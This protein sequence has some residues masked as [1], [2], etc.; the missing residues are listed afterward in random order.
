M[1]LSASIRPFDQRLGSSRRSL[2]RTMSPA[3]PLAAAAKNSPSVTPS[4]EAIFSIE[5]IE[6]E[7]T[8]FSTW[9]MKLA[10]KSVR[11][12]RARRDMRFSVRSWRTQAPTACCLRIGDMSSLPTFRE[13]AVRRVPT[14]MMTYFA[15]TF[16]WR[17]RGAII[18]AYGSFLLGWGGAMS[19]QS[20]GAPFGFVGLSAALI[21]LCAV[22]ARSAPPEGR[23]RVTAAIANVRSDAST[24]GGVL[25]QAKRGDELLVLGEVGDWYHVQSM[26][27]WQGYMKKDLA[28]VIAARSEEHT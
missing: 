23:L 17:L 25:F 19:R 21:L 27:G 6:G 18:A 12:A 1:G 24:K 7:T 10:E 15:P 14:G 9:E 4:A 13:D 22:D 2:V 11:L 16:D 26:A 3:S 8:P 5:A 20:A 28:E